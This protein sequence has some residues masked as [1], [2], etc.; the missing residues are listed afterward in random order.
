MIHIYVPTTVSYLIWST[1]ISQPYVLSD[2]IHLYISQP[3]SPNHSLLS[4]MVHL[5]FPTIYIIR[6]G[7][8]LSPN[9]Y[10]PSDMVLLPIA[11]PQVPPL[12][13]TASTYML[14]LDPQ[15]LS[16]T[17]ILHFY[18]SYSYF[19]PLFTPTM[20]RSLKTFVSFRPVYTY[21]ILIH[22]YLSILQNL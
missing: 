12:Y 3:L 18:G 21:N 14:Y 5:Y 19:L 17:S 13:L 22:N 16:Y 20:P 8:P 4:D 15:L 7:P 9:H 1:F 6:Y 2:M 11:Q 10:L